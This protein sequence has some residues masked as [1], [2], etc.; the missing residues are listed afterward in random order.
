MIPTATG[1]GEVLFA[2]DESIPTHGQGKQEASASIRF[3][4]NENRDAPGS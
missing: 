1:G 3:N 2:T 4:H